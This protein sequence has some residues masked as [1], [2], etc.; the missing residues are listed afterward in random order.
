MTPQV[1]PFTCQS[2]AHGEPAAAVWHSARV[3]AYGPAMYAWLPFIMAVHA[4]TIEHNDVHIFDTDITAA[5]HAACGHA[6]AR[7][8]AQ[9]PSHA[10]GQANILLRS[11]NA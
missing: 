1:P 5:L 3:A 8:R 4:A 2:I 11:M 10:V 6:R 9:T 7:K